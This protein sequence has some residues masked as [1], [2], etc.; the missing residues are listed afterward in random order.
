MLPIEIWYI[1]KK[2]YNKKFIDLISPYN[3]KFI[4][5]LSYSNSF[6]SRVLENQEL[7]FSSKTL[8]ATTGGWLLK[9]YSLL[10]S[11]FE[12]VLLM[13]A[14]NTPTKNP[15]YI[16]ESGPYKE[17]GAYYFPDKPHEEEKYKL[18]PRICEIFGIEYIGDFSFDSG[19]MFI[20][21][22][23]CLLQ[24]QVALWWNEFPEFTYEI[25]YG[26]KDTFNLSWRQ[27]NKKYYLVEKMPIPG[28]GLQQ[29]DHNGDI[30]FLHRC[31]QKWKIKK[32]IWLNRP[33]ENLLHGFIDELKY[34][35][36]SLL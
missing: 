19:Q 7:C 31:G 2:E 1:G 11:S 24:L 25:I 21:K 20:N 23:K 36:N 10:H 22:N 9:S 6:P 13:D 28:Y 29:F 30:L 34:Y 4:D 33:Q 26:D 15:E 27:T 18:S 3:V 32:N 17:F 16:F 8:N 14:D 12:E 35:F 5:A